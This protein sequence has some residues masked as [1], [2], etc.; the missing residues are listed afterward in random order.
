MRAYLLV[1]AFAV[2]LTATVAS[3]Q[4]TPPPGCRWMGETLACKDGR[5]NWRRAGDDEIVGTYPMPKAR[6]KPKAAPAPK[7]AVVSAAP[8]TRPAPPQDRALAP[9]PPLE[10]PPVYAEANAAA[11]AALPA[12][13]EAQAVETFI[14]PPQ[15][16][17][18]A[19]PPKPKPWWQAILDWIGSQFDELLR[20]VGLKK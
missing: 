9:L 4:D 5:G 14:N 6:P 11:E 17:E 1:M 18:V 13:E 7:P 2:G 20:L 10:A 15:P 8:P 19:A 16:A 3:A 12:V